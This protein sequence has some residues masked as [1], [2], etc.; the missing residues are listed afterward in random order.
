LLLAR[1]SEAERSAV[2]VEHQSPLTIRKG[3]D[4]KATL[5]M[6]FGSKR[7]CTA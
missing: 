1:A 6:S 7:N 5:P 3:S 2:P 4:W